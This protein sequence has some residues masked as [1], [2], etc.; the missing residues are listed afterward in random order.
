MCP[1]EEGRRLPGEENGIEVDLEND[2]DAANPKR[3]NQKRNK[4]HKENLVMAV[5]RSDTPSTGKKAKT[6]VPR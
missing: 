6:E 1:T 2:D 3:K 4:N 5:E